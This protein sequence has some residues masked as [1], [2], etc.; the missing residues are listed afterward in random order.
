MGLETDQA[1]SWG[2]WNSTK[3]VSYME[4]DLVPE[5]DRHAIIIQQLD[6]LLEDRVEKD[7][8]ALRIPP[9]GKV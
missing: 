4:E 8:I 9:K 7:G 5:T 6:P 2:I 1:A 3:P